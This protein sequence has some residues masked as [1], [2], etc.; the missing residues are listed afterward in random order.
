[1]TSTVQLIGCG[2]AKAIPANDL[3]VGDV[4]VWNYGYTES[5]CGIIPKGKQSLVLHVACKSGFYQR[6]VRRNRL[7]AVAR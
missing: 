4:T 5:I 2:T 1:M 3:K 6:T 7:V